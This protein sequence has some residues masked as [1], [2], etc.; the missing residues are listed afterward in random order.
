MA[1]FCCMELKVVGPSTPGIMTS[2]RMASG[3]SGGRDGDTFGAGAGGEDL[4]ACRGLEGE[5]GDFANVVF[6]INNQNASHERIYSL[7]QRS[8]DGR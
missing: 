7:M 4:P 1:G 8:G 5:G 6:V 3:C 2:M